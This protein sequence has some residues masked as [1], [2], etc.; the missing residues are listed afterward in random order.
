[1]WRQGWPSFPR[2]EESCEPRVPYETVHLIRL[3]ALD[4]P[5]RRLLIL[6]AVRFVYHMRDIVMVFP[7]RHIAAFFA[8][9]VT[10]PPAALRAPHSL[11]LCLQ[12]SL[13][14]HLCAEQEISAWRVSRDG[15]TDA[16]QLD[17]GEG[18]SP[19]I[20]TRRGNW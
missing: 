9:S 13:A 10:P 20:G 4:I 12:L 16:M 8:R 15:S 2:C 1:M 14:S 6:P 5:V 17:K 3:A 19:G 7:P 11:P 18:Y